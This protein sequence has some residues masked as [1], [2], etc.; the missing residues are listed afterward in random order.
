MG[1]LTNATGMHALLR[2][3][4]VLATLAVS[5]VALLAAPAGAS[6]QTSVQRCYFPSSF[7]CQK[8]N[9]T[10]AKLDSES[11]RMVSQLRNMS[12]GVDPQSTFDCARAVMIDNPLKWT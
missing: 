9:S 11:T 3:I 10:K 12:Y 4:V 5:A 6:A 8:V 1:R 2:P 7:F